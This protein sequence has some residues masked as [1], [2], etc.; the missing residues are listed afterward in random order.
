MQ[1]ELT[2]TAREMI[3]LLRAAQSIT[4]MLFFA[5][6][7]KAL[8]KPSKDAS[9]LRAVLLLWGIPLTLGALLITYG[10]VPRDLVLTLFPIVTAL[11]CLLAVASL[12]WRPAREAMARMSDAEVRHLMAFRAIFG[13]FIL[14]GTAA[15]L[16]P[17]RF[18]W[19]GGLGDLIVSWLA[20]AS[21]T[22]L[23]ARG[24]KPMRVLV[25]GAGVLDLMQVGFHIV[26]LVI[27]WLRGND[28]L[29]PTAF[30]PWIAVPLMLALNLHGLRQALT[31]STATKPSLKAA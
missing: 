16:F 1:D 22:S 25:H 28:S 31:E 3:P 23:A 24:A 8:I 17:A 13:M 26:T 12:A 10:G 5:A 4:A 7:W 11:S 27:P 21:P 18:A 20:T 2:Q 9:R 30:L 6:T 19:T 15:G 29:G 14:G